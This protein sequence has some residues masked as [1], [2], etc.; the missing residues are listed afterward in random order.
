VDDAGAMP[1]SSDVDDPLPPDRGLR[2]VGAVFAAVVLLVVAA[3]IVI[4][5][6]EAGA[7]APSGLHTTVHGTAA[8]VTA[9]APGG[10][11]VTSRWRPRPPPTSRPTGRPTPPGASRTAHNAS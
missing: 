10:T 6:V 2:K 7:T 3:A 4:P 11:P 5:T 8:V 1:S 9:S